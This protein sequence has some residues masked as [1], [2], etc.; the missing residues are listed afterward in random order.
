MIKFDELHW[1]M[2]RKIYVPVVGDIMVTRWAYEA[3]SVEQFKSNRFEKPFF[4]YDMEI[5]QNEWY[6]SFLVPT[7]KAKT[8]E[9]LATGKNPEEKYYTV[10]NLRKI[11]Y[12]VHDLA[13][14]SG[15]EPGKWIN[16]LNYDDFND[17]TADEV[18]GYLDSLKTVFR[19]RSKSFS[20]SRDQLYKTISSKM[21]EE[22]FRNLRQKNYNENLADIVM[23]NMA[24]NK[25]YDAGDRF[26]QKA[27]PIF[28]HPGSKWGRS[29]FFAPFK[30]LGNLKIETLIFNLI[31][32]WIMSGVLFV[33]LYF[34]GL[35]RFI[36]VLESLKLPIIRKYGR[37]LLQV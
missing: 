37:E 6:A 17:H 23:N 31:M 11:S 33:T 28:M 9:V 15:K 25:I 12:H 4:Y 1:S 22:A 32:I 13:E 27:D 10:H 30:Q 3:M 2:S 21:G 35:K 20:E 5:S 36:A 8:Q 16:N 14:I 24:K 19:T 18:K 26:I 7:L 29:Q 34:N